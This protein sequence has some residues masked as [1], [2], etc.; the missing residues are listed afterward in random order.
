MDTWLCKVS[1]FV[2]FIC[3]LS[4]FLS[5]ND[6]LSYLLRSRCGLLWDHILIEPWNRVILQDLKVKLDGVRDE[7]KR[8]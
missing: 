8:V 7:I 4:G 5:L 1:F 3:V 2:L 6:F